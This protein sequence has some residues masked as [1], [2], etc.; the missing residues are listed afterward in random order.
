MFLKNKNILY[1]VKH[2]CLFES[3]F[4][5]RIIYLSEYKKRRDSLECT[6]KCF[7]VLQNALAFSARAYYSHGCQDYDDNGTNY[8]HPHA[9][10]VAPSL[11]VSKKGF[12]P[13]APGPVFGVTPTPTIVLRPGNLKIIKL[14]RKELSSTNRVRV[15][16][17]M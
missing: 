3:K 15:K 17:C 5:S 4:Q 1:E 8:N 11:V 6:K 7:N 14:F 16:A 13:S 12:Q 10:H 2:I 9:G